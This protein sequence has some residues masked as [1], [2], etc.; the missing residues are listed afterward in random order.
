MVDVRLSAHDPQGYRQLWRGTV[1]G[2]ISSICQ[3]VSGNMP[4]AE[5]NCHYGVQMTVTDI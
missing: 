3:Q 2:G 4:S 5:H 1:L